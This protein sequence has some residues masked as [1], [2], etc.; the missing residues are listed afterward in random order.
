MEIDL[1][2]SEHAIDKFIFLNPNFTDRDKARKVLIKLFKTAK[3]VKINPT[4]AAI[5]LMNNKK[6][7]NNNDYKKADYY[8]VNGHR[9]VVVDNTV[10]TFEKKYKGKK[11]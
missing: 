3:K 5:R 9:F 11:K 10:V 6:L 7:Y 4:I 2:I 1:I 8:E